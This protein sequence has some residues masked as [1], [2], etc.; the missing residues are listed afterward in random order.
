MLERGIRDTEVFL[1]RFACLWQ[2]IEDFNPQGLN[3]QLLEFSWSIVIACDRSAVENIPGKHNTCI[4]GV[5]TTRKNKLL[6]TVLSNK[7]LHT[8]NSIPF[9][10][11]IT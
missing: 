10:E 3:A 2:G 11:L 9:T 7:M 1:E 4:A 6:Q 5:Q 8:S